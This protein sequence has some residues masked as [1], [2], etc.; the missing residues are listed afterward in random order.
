[1]KRERKLREERMW[2]ERNNTKIMYRR[3]TVIVHICTVIVA[4][5]HLCTILH[6][7]HLCIYA[8]FYTHWYGCFLVKVYKISYFCILHDFARVDGVAP[9]DFIQRPAHY[10]CLVTQTQCFF[11]ITP[12]I[13]S[14]WEWEQ[15]IIIIIITENCL[16]IVFKH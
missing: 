16:L 15:I 8:Q 6:P 1:M 5:V 3:V 14:F 9:C 2:G 12:N 4:L 10:N 11:K 13:H 7:Q